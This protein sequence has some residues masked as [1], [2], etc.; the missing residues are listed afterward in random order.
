MY[1]GCLE[2]PFPDVVYARAIYYKAADI[3]SHLDLVQLERWFHGVGI[4]GIFTL[5]KAAICALGHGTSAGGRPRKYALIE[6]IISTP[7]GADMGL[8]EARRFSLF[9]VDKFMATGA[10]VG[11]HWHKD[12]RLDMHILL[13]NDTVFGAALGSSATIPQTGRKYR[14]VEVVARY[15]ADLAHEEL[16]K[17]RREAGRP[18]I[19]TMMETRASLKAKRLK[20]ENQYKEELAAG[21]AAW[22]AYF[23]T[24]EASIG[25]V[26]DQGAAASIPPAETIED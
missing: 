22:S 2:F 18:V 20:L 14:N 10:M 21:S 24:V 7:E 11:G 19:A 16:N 25:S 13:V 15:I 6:I 26:T 23:K 4:K 3:E 1:A 9:L 5:R 17:R 12:G 8:H